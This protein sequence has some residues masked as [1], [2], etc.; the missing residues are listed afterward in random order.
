MVA[1][2]QSLLLRRETDAFAIFEGARPCAVNVWACVIL[3]VA[4]VCFI[5]AFS[6]R[7]AYELTVNRD[8]TVVVRSRRVF[9]AFLFPGERSQTSEITEIVFTTLIEMHDNTVHGEITEIKLRNGDTIKV[10]SRA[11]ST[12]HT[13]ARVVSLRVK[14]REERDCWCSND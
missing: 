2:E 1:F 7:Y 4:V 11:K 5:I 3:T 9:G 10:R 12:A 14:A 13:V 8:G 6:T